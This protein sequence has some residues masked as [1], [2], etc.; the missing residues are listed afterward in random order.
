MRRMRAQSRYENAFEHWF[1]HVVLPLSAYALLAASAVAAFRYPVEAQ[2]AVAA[3]T[4]MFAVC[5]NPQRL[6]RRHLACAGAAD[7]RAG[8]LI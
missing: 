5:R 1:F 7:E 4:L 3:A 2:F 6:G 8:W